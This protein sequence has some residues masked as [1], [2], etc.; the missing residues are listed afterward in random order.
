MNCEERGIKVVYSEKE[1][2]KEEGKRERRLY[3]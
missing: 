1:G 2:D 3:R